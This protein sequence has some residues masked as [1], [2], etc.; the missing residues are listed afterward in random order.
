[1]G[2]TLDF[3]DISSED[4]Q[5]KSDVQL[6]DSPMTS[7]SESDLTHLKDYYQSSYGESMDGKDDAVEN[8]IV[9]CKFHTKCD[10]HGWVVTYSADNPASKHS[11]C[12]I[13][14]QLIK[15]FRHHFNDHVHFL[16]HV[17]WYDFFEREKESKIVVVDTSKQSSFNPTISIANVSKPLIYACDKDTSKLF[18]LNCPPNVHTKED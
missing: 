10:N 17:M 3:W 8:E 15:T 16:L 18:V 14:S 4:E 7:L 9:L 5:S 1:M 6:C 2:S 12:I 11:S 13:Y